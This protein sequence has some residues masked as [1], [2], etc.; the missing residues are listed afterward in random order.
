[1]M[2]IKTCFER[3]SSEGHKALMPYIT[4]GDPAS[5]TVDIMHK[6]VASG[7]NLIELGFPFSDP[8]ADGPVIAEAHE[9][10][11]SQGVTL[12]DVFSMVTRFRENDNN[13][14]IVLM[15]YLNPVEIMG[16]EAFATRAAEAGVDG[17][18]I[19]DLPAEFAGDL[20][21]HLK[22]RQIDMINL[23]TP[24]TTDE[25]IQKICSV[26]SGFVY[27]VSVKG[28]TGSNK[29]DLDSVQSRVAHIKGF[30]DLPVGVGF[31]IRD[32]ESAAA[33]ASVADGVVVG[34]LLVSE[35]ANYESQGEGAIDRVSGHLEAMRQ[36]MDKG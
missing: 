24:T 28:V 32:G 33:I 17:V 1:M 5:K 13:T 36:A 12:N 20:V 30:T 31:G 35:L 34:S 15:G 29:L 19:V 10:A 16:Y 3:L 2:R 11:L 7:A 4:A 23:I 25:R 9:R 26:A 8:M 27:Y 21:E 14:P 22:P 6:V 18:L